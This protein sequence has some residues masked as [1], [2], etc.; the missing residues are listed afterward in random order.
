MIYA[1]AAAVFVLGNLWAWAL[2]R[3]AAA[4]DR[5]IERGTIAKREDVL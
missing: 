4:G 5:I 2:C 3:A 1:L